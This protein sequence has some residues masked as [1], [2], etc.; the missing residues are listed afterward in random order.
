M[1]GCVVYVDG[2]VVVVECI[3][4]EYVFVV[5]DHTGDVVVVVVVCCCD[6]GSMRVF[7]HCS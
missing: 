3:V 4:V 1:F 5:C 2:F 7:C 6:V